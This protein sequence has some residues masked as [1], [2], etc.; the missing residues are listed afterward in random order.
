MNFAGE[1]QQEKDFLACRADDL[2]CIVDMAE[3][4]I[5]EYEQLE[6]KEDIVSNSWWQN[7]R[8]RTVG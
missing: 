1:S 7:F 6:S 3:A 4:L 8:F 2:L 5:E